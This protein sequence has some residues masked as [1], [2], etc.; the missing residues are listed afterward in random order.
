MPKK[1]DVCIS[2]ITN[3]SKLSNLEIE[4]VLIELMIMTQ[5]K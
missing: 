2:H 1:I 5:K 4:K 3:N